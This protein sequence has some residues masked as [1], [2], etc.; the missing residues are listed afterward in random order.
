MGLF[1]SLFLIPSLG[2]C[3]VRPFQFM[4]DLGRPLAP[5]SVWRYVIQKGLS[6]RERHRQVD[7][8]FQSQE[9]GTSQQ[10]SPLVSLTGPLPSKAFYML[11]L[12]VDDE[13]ELTCCH[14]LIWNGGN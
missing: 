8:W 7:R 1:P 12:I 10:R 5:G 13:L 2:P 11:L 3:P 9:R 4:S 6:S 14:T